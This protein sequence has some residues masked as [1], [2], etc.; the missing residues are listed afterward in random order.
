MVRVFA[1]CCYANDVVPCSG[2]DCC[3]VQRYPGRTAVFTAVYDTMM[4]CMV[5]VFLGSLTHDGYIP[6]DTDIRAHSA[7]G[8]YTAVPL[9]A[10]V[11]LYRTEILNACRDFDVC[12]L[13]NCDACHI[14][15][16]M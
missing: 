11:L 12:R 15:V 4:P 7:V 9:H 16:C 6:F 1:G 13:G 3:I 10:P 8:V 2:T 14:A 5:W